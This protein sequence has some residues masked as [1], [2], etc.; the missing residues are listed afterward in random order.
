MLGCLFYSAT[1]Q[2]GAYF[3]EGINKPIHLENVQC[4]GLEREL[5][6]CGKGG[7]N[8]TESGADHSLDVGVKC[9]PGK[10]ISHSLLRD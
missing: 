5:I 8:H 6:N 2:P 4:S 9:E 10:I 1:A 7:A 3:G